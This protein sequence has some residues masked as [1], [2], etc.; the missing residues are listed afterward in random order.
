MVL[1]CNVMSM[2][3]IQ[4][5]CVPKSKNKK[6]EEK[7]IHT[8]WKLWEIASAGSKSD[9]PAIKPVRTIDRSRRQIKLKWIITLSNL[10]RRLWIMIERDAICVFTYLRRFNGIRLLLQ[11]VRNEHQFFFY[12]F[13][14][15]FWHHTMIW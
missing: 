7:E 5:F 11:T 8:S 6:K 2:T 10:N 9:V 13:I 15:Y 1:L 3:L 12:I 4:K 14:I